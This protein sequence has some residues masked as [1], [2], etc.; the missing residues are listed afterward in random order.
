MSNVLSIFIRNF[1]KGGITVGIALSI[2]ELIPKT[3]NSIGFYAAMSGS[4]FYLNFL[5]YYYIVNY[6]KN[7]KISFL[8]NT[9]L[10]GI[11]W[12]FYAGIM[13]LFYKI[14]LTDNI[15]VIITFLFVMLIS[16]TYYNNMD[17]ISDFVQ[18]IL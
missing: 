1:V 14:K 4:F 18:K 9:L 11:I 7:T 10:G 15:N 16:L 17:L 8:G 6:V 3:N 13:V 12:V 5:Q 2:L